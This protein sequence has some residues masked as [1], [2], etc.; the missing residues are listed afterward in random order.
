VHKA[1]RQTAGAEIGDTVEVELELDTR[2]REVQVP[3][4]LAAALAADPGAG[5]TFEKLPFTRRREHAEAIAGAKRE[6]TRRRRLAKI[7]AEL[8][9]EE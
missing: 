4:E 1:T 8:R 6:E 3:A 7:M 9:G 5:A 2:P